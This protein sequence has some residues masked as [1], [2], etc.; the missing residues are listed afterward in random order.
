MAD[1]DSEDT[2][3]DS[4]LEEEGGE[5]E[6]A[7]PETEEEESAEAGGEEQETEEGTE[8]E[9]TEAEGGEGPGDEEESEEG[10]EDQGER[11]QPSRGQSRIQRLNEERNRL[12]AENEELRRRAGGGGGQGGDNTR[13]QAPTPQAI[14][15]NVKKSVQ[16]KLG[17]DFSVLAPDQQADR[18]LGAMEAVLQPVIRGLQGNQ[19]AS[20]DKSQFYEDRRGNRWVERNKGEIERRFQAALAQG[21]TVPREQIA[22]DMAGEQALTGIQKGGGSARRQASNRKAAARGTPTRGRGDSGG[23]SKAPKEGTLEY[24][25]KNLEDVKI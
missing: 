11:T 3:L 17:P 20:N 4:I 7:A 16:E 10:E 13:T 8:S 23:R 9:E 18:L 24:Y 2:L 22:R 15:E 19:F 25:E 6:Q 5:Q 1:E 21:Y 14:R 12:R